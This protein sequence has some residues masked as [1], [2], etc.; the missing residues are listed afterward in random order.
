L[1]VVPPIKRVPVAPANLPLLISGSTT[2]KLLNT[3]A[4]WS[5]IPVS[6]VTSVPRAVKISSF[7]L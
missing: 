3:P 6:R 5:K 7:P 1:I 2:S 4:S